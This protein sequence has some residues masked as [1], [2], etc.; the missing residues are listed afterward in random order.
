MD[1]PVKVNPPV[2]SKF[3]NVSETWRA[4]NLHSESPM[5]IITRDAD[6]RSIDCE[7]VE[8]QGRQ[9]QGAL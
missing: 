8:I 6:I 7:A 4:S 5:L 9:A 2:I 1:S 3:R